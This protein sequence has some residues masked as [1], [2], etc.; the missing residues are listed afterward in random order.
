[1]RCL[2]HFTR[3]RVLRKD[4]WSRERENGIYCVALVALRRCSR[5]LG[6][7]RASARLRV[8][9]LAFSASS[10]FGVPFAASFRSSTPSSIASSV[11]IG[12]FFFSSITLSTASCISLLA[13][14]EFSLQRFSRHWILSLWQRPSVRSCRISLHVLQTHPLALSTPTMRHSAARNILIA[15][16]TG[17]LRRPPT[18][19][20]KP[21]AGGLTG[22]RSGGRQPR[23]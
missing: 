5:R 11:P 9:R 15:R 22:G 17:S 18:K 12:S 16:T 20:Y 14:S 2:K 6:A 4:H 8:R 3:K 10:F 23:Q 13:T 19:K 21:L 1:M 7:R